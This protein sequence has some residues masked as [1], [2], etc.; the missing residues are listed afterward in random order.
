MTP[1]DAAAVSSELLTIDASEAW[2]RLRGRSVGRLAVSSAGQP[3]IFP[4]NYLASEHSILIRTTMGTK[5]ATIASNDLVALEVDEIGPS[6]AWSVVVKG[7]ARRLVEE[8]A[9]EQARKSPLW[10]WAPMP[11]D[12][13]VR[14][15]P[16]E[17]TGRYFH[18]D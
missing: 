11:T 16:G 3:A 13:F 17:I 14:I 2:N 12:A 15:L 8:A 5:L 18:R 9:I 7:V 6:E 10:T 1:L 4:V